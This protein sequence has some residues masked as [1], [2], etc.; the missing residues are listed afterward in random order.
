LF[1]TTEGARMTTIT[2]LAAQLAE[3]IEVRDTAATQLHDA[4]AKVDG[5]SSEMTA[6]AK[7]APKAAKPKAGA[8]RRAARVPVGEMRGRSAKAAGDAVEQ[9]TNGAVEWDA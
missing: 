6:R 9:P 4:Q 8:R 5:L 7:S 3:A 1:T 2:E